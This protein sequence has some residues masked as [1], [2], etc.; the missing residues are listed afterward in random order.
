[1]TQYADR[2]FYTD[3]YK[4]SAIPDAVFDYW[5]TQAS[6]RID[7]VTFDRSTSAEG[8]DLEKIKM[9]TCAVAE[10]MYKIETAG[11]IITSEKVGSYSRT[12]K[13]P[14]KDSKKQRTYDAAKLYLGRT[15]LMYRGIDDVL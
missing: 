9:A 13:V 6:G 2:T 5:A 3:T 4:G 1:M 15:G 14:E 7:E 8:E 10:V 12:V 11:G